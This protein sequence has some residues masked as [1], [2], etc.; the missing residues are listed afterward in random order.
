VQGWD[1]ANYLKYKD[2]WFWS[3]PLWFKDGKPA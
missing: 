1:H 2:V 3:H